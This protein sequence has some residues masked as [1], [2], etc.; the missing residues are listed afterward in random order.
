MRGHVKT[1]GGGALCNTEAANECVLKKDTAETGEGGGGVRGGS[2]ISQVLLD[3][4]KSCE[5]RV[6][7][8]D[9]ESAN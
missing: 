6:L 9:G 2:L 1:H 7:G 4:L 8:G 5:G 3:V